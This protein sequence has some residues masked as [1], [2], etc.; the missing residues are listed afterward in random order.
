MSGAPAISVV[1]ATRDRRDLVG[2]LLQALAEQ[3]T[4][5]PFE[6]VLVDDASKDGTADFAESMRDR[7][8]FE[9]TVLR[10]P[11][12][13]GP[14]QSRN[15]GW[16]EAKSDRIAFTDDDCVPDPGWLE[17]IKQS[18]ADHDVVI[19]RTRPPDDQLHLIGPF[20]SYL[21]LGHNGTYSTCN[22]GYRRAVLDRVGGFDPDF[23]W[24]NGEDTDLGIRSR[25]SGASE[26]YTEVALVWHDVHPSQFRTYFRRLRRLE[27]LVALVARHPEVRDD[28][29]RGS[30]FLR[31][32]DKA[33]L[34]GLGSAGMAALI[35]RPAVS[36]LL[37]A[38][39]LGT[40]AWQFPKAYYPARSRRELAET[41]PR[42]FVADVYTVGVMVRSSVRWRTV[43][44]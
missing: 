11:R 31:S 4:S 21:D 14:G 40:Y 6:L 32:I 34:V 5:E 13:L 43:L 26:V 35:R 41:L 27:G 20:S 36:A 22:I 23:K 8:P 33:V 24:P 3:Q 2:R 1:V 19:G 15:R 30:L 16:R 44:L 7:F 10:Q 9:L 17:A 42:A 28:L 12:S 39:G 25:K 38:L 18:L 29:F 37:V